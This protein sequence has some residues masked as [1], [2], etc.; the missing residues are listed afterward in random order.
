[1]VTENPATGNAMWQDG[2]DSVLELWREVAP[3]LLP[4]TGQAS[5]ELGRN[6]R[7]LGKSRNHWSSLHSKV[8]LRYLQKK[9]TQ[10]RAE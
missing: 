4:Q 9:G 2:F 6:P 1:M 7:A 3:E 5:Q 8:G 10:T